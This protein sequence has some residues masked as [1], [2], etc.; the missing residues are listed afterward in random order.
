MQTRFHYCDVMVNDIGL[1]KRIDANIQLL[2]EPQHQQYGGGS[3]GPGSCPVDQEAR[4][5]SN[6]KFLASLDSTAVFVPTTAVHV[7]MISA[8]FWPHL[9]DEPMHIPRLL[10]APLGRYAKY[11]VANLSG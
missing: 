9:K 11:V 5:H 4:S 7:T 3:C 6:K 1:S 10:K 8:E 2:M